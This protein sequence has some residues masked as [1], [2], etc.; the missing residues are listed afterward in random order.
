M[1]F[2]TTM[3]YDCTSSHIFYISHF[4]FWSSY[5][6]C[7]F[8]VFLFWYMWAVSHATPYNCLIRSFE[9]HSWILRASNKFIMWILESKSWSWHIW[10]LYFFGVGVCIRRL[11]VYMKNRKIN[12]H[13]SSSYIFFSGWEEDAIILLPH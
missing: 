7:M 1:K 4:F 13:S 9:I 12:I 11:Y 6:I 2:T 3:N 5:T 8:F 10:Y